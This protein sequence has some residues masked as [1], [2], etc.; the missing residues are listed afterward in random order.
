MNTLSN[1]KLAFQQANIKLFEAMDNSEDGQEIFF[2]GDND[3]QEFMDFL[4][5]NEVKYAFY[6]HSEVTEESLINLELITEEEY[7]FEAKRF[8][9]E[10][11]EYNK[12]VTK[13]MGDLLTATLFTVH[14]GLFISVIID[15]EL[16]DKLKEDG[17]DALDSLTSEY[18]DEMEFHKIEREQELLRE[19]EEDKAQER[20][21]RVHK[22]YD[23]LEKDRYFASLTTKDGR[24]LRA[25]ELAAELGLKETKTNI[26]GYLDVFLT[27]KKMEKMKQN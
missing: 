17:E 26:V 3:F 4:A 8:K 14:N 11:K 1:I 7:G 16:E 25:T 5:M 12:L 10:A 19:I 21:Q 6:T 23:L 15:S 2:C 27:R 13:H 24:I 9:K 22:F 18:R 20:K